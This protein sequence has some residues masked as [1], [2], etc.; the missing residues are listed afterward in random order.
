MLYF[1]KQITELLEWLLL[2]R[3]QQ[4]NGD[5]EMPSTMVLAESISIEILNVIIC[6]YIED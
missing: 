3:C 2:R 1:N 5:R 4:H 6:S